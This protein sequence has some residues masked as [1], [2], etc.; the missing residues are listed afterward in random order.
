M[1]AS[2]TRTDEP[3]LDLD[4]EIQNDMPPGT[5]TRDSQFVFARMPELIAQKATA[6]RTRPRVLDVGA[7]FGGQMDMLRTHGA[8]AWG[9]D[10]SREQMYYCTLR[11]ADAP[12]PVV[13]AIAEALPFRD[14]SFDAVVCQG[15]LDHFVQPRDFMRECARILKPDGRAIIAISNFDSLSCRLGR[16]LYALKERLGREVYRGRNF[17]QIPANHT[18]K[19][20][21]KV[22]TALGEPHLELVE[23]RGASL[24]WLFH[25]WTRLMEALPEGIAWR[26]LRAADTIAY[27]APSLADV[28]VSVWRP[29]GK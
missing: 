14:N 11:F 26:A 27:R 21:T 18:F 7:G 5:P 8:E 24:M 10:A 9:L 22:L 19:G 6:G 2:P 13:A 25:R 1:T 15:S 17:W 28:A 20:T 16:G 29:R 12:A 3:Q 23:C 4:Y